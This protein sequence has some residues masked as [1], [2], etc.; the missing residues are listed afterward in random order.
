MET[1]VV[2]VREFIWTSDVP[3]II[4]SYG[5]LPVRYVAALYKEGHSLTANKVRSA[6]CGWMVKTGYKPDTVYIID[7]E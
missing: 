1:A 2:I 5:R 7:A 6:E 4:K 3:A